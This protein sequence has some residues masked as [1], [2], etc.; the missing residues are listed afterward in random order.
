MTR[1]NIIDAVIQTV[2]E[3]RKDYVPRDTGNMAFNSLKYKVE[4]NFI[5]VYVD[6]NIAPYVPYTNE[7]W[8]SPKWNG[9]K[10][11]NQD[12]WDVFANEFIQRFNTRLRGTIK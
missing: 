2:E 7:P 4:G 6:T 10:N 5:V 8:I 11:P 9:K 1:Q 3:L 12:W